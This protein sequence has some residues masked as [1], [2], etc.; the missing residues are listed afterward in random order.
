[1]MNILEQIFSKHLIK[2]IPEIHQAVSTDF[3]K[4]KTRSTENIPP[5]S[6]WLECYRRSRVIF[7][8]TILSVLEKNKNASI[9]LEQFAISLI[10]KNQKNQLIE[11]VINKMRTSSDEERMK[12]NADIAD[13]NA[14]LKHKCDVIFSETY[15]NVSKDEAR[16]FTSQLEIRFF[17]RVI[18]PCLALYGKLPSQ[19][20][21]K[22]RLGD[23]NAIRQLAQIDYS[24]VHDKK[25]SRYIHNLAFRNPT[26]HRSLIRS[27]VRDHPRPKIKNLK[28]DAAALIYLFNSM[29]SKAFNKKKMT[30]PQLRQLFVD[31][32]K[33][34]GQTDDNDL[35]TGE[36]LY[37]NLKQN[38]LW[39]GLM[40]YPEKK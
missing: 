1:M 7:N 31:E 23:E 27:L 13:Y 35:P 12:F 16:S 26:N 11:N 17:S 18:L 37:K 4:N 3:I 2:L 25:I 28:T 24:V 6:C 10:P 20:L 33:L 34:L 9:L 5:L 39:D 32:A 36:T 40:K 38:T 14:E 29:F 22:A 19:M 21:R 8:C 15:K 30:T